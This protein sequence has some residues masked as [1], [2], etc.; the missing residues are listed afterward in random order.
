[1]H[2]DVHASN[3]F[4]THDPSIQASEDS[5]CLKPPGNCDRLIE[6]LQTGKWSTLV[7]NVGKLL[8]GCMASDLLFICNLC[9]YWLKAITVAGI[10]SYLTTMAVSRLYVGP[11]GRMINEC[12]AVGGMRTGRGNRS[13][14]RNPSSLPFCP[15]Q[16]P[17]VVGLN[18][19]H[20][21]GK[22]EK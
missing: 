21:S 22:P 20:S 2:T 13:I 6:Y 15:S 9:S 8:P 5:S 7:R 1:M 19:G 17:H 3:G 10:L 14:R 11:N 4:R 16:I 18:P 12:E